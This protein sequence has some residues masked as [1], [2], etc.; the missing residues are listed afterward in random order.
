[1]VTGAAARVTLRWRFNGP[2]AVSVGDRKLN[3]AKAADGS[4]S[5]EFDHQG[6]SRVN[7]E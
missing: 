7:W 5:V 3:T 2:T 4:V 1:V 6:T